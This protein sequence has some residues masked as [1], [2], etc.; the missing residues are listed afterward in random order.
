MIERSVESSPFAVPD[1]IETPALVVDL[2][3]LTANLRELTDLCRDNGVE[4]LP[5]AK[6]HRTVEIGQLQMAHGADG[7]T[8]ATVEEAEAFVGGGIARVLIAYPL[9]GISKVQR[10]FQL[11]QHVEVTL[12]ADSVE[13]AREIGRVFAESG[14]SADLLLIVDTGMARCGVQPKD[15]VEFASE[16]ARQPGINLLGLMTHEGSVYNASDDQDIVDRSIACATVMV[17]AADAVRASGLAIDVVSMGSSASFRSIIGFPGV[18]QIRPGRYAFNDFGLMAL[19]LATLETCAVRVLATVVSHADP[20][21]ACIDAGSKSLSSDRLPSRLDQ[22][23]PGFGMIVDHPGWE[24]HR[25]SEEHGWLR[26][27]GESEPEPLLIGQRVE[28][29]P[30]HICTAFFSRAESLLAQRGEVVAKWSTLP[31]STFPAE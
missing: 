20:R 25:L 12:A 8:V 1:G 30:N 24:I 16:M 6:T 17:E 14:Q 31:R 7:L 26:W 22:E 13:G 27:V 21:R 23:H 18:T 29:I 15:V 4:Q 5:H 10:A 2:D 11:A 28:V 19:G 9:V 3:I